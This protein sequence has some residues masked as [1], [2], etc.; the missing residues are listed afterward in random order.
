[1]T[2]LEGVVSI[3]ATRPVFGRSPVAKPFFAFD[4][5][6]STAW[7]TGAFGSA[8]GNSITIDFGGPRD[9]EDV[10]VQAA[11]SRPVRIGAIRVEAGDK[12]IETGLRGSSPAHIALDASD[13]TSL[14]VTITGVEGAGRNPVGIA[15]I[16][17]SGLSV[18]EV[19][20]LPTSYA[21]LVHD[22]GDAAAETIGSLPLDVVLTRQA[23][24]PQSFFDDEERSLDRV[25]T[26]PADRSFTFEATAKDPNLLSLPAHG[27]PVDAALLTGCYAIAYVDGRPIEGRL[28]GVAHDDPGPYHVVPCTDEPFELAAGSHRL[29]TSIGWILDELHLSSPGTGAA[30]AA[31]EPVPEGPTVDVTSSSSTRFSVDVGPSEAPYYLVSGQSF[32]PRWHASVD[33][34]DL[35]PPIVVDGY[36][37]GWRLEAGPA[38]RVEITYGPQRVL[39][40]T[41]VV[42]GVAVAGVLGF[43]AWTWWVRRRETPW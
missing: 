12:S 25:F 7:Q 20:A 33:G 3:S 43:L 29:R 4:S 21:T 24:D 9:V 38:H 36:S 18:G 1:V 14:T 32:D 35:G 16:S 28:E 39:Q 11:E 27:L 41:V 5:D 10:V 17:V 37:A 34:H 13:V 42:S 31:E 26:L 6:P 23:G 22:A 40:A 2:R 8:V 30:P 15:E 19:T